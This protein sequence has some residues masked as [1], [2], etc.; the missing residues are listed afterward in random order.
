MEGCK[1]VYFQAL[2]DVPRDSYYIATKVC[3]Y[4]PKK[5]DMC[6]FSYERTRRSVDES[7][8]RLGLDYIDLV[9]VRIG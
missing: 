6:D 9:Q 7:L 2:R 1:T 8:E 5:E 3:R 4:S